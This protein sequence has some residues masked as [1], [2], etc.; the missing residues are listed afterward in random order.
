MVDRADLPKVNALYGE[1]NNI[2]QTLKL[3]AEGGRIIN[4]TVG[5]RSEGTPQFWQ[6]TS[7]AST[8]YMDY[9]PS[10]KDAIVGFFN[11]RLVQ[12]TGELE[13]LGVTGIDDEPEPAR[14]P[15]HA[16]AAAPPKRR[17]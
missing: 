6:F 9:P 3:F 13:E 16:Q 11:Q 2:M 5:K 7:S 12:I 15:A 4:L 17:K 10:M 1:R 14:A 8:E